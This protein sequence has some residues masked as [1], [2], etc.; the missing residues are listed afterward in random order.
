MGKPMQRF[1]PTPPFSSSVFPCPPILTS[2][3]P[4]PHL[5]PDIFSPFHLPRHFLVFPSPIPTITFIAPE[6]LSFPA[7]E[8][9]PPWIAP[10]SLRSAPPPHISIVRIS[11][12]SFTCLSFPFMPLSYYIIRA[13][14]LSL[15][16]FH[17]L[18]HTFTCFSEHGGHMPP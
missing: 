2:F 17:I 8:V 16:P 11:Y 4:A 6:L 18:V 7:P 12:E 15:R 9:V 5:P 13:H 14:L 3:S 1:C 10:R